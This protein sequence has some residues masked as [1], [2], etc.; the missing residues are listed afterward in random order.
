MDKSRLEA[1]SDGV[2]AVA[3]TLLVLDLHVDAGS[4]QSLAHQLGAEWPSFAAYVI[5]FFIIGVIW[6]NHHALFA[7][8]ASV[9]RVVM[10][11]NLVLLMW[12]ATIPFTT[13]TLAG[14]LRRGGGD[15]RLSV[16]LYGASMEG[17][18]VS[19]T[20]I[21]RRLVRGHLL[22]QPIGVAEGRRAIRRFGAGSAIY[23]VIMAVG[24]VVPVVMLVLYGLL[25]AYYIAQQTPI[26]PASRAGQES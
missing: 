4:E 19:F 26:L 7:L 5:S 17:M 9:D 16:V 23:P 13:A 15:A 8:A 11:L 10:F 18:A 3:I 20:M 1:F 21:L 12:V 25:T 6:V 2:L 14:Y 22:L 24:L